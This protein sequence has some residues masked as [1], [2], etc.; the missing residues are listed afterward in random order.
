M[1]R[2]YFCEEN[3]FG[4]V[5]FGGGELVSGNTVVAWTRVVMGGAGGVTGGFSGMLEL[6][7]FGH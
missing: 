5:Q 4:R 7:E 3:G 1:D 2:S 6:P